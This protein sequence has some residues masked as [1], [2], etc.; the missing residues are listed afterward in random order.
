VAE[1]I[2]ISDT[3]TSQRLRR[4]M[5]NVLSDATDAHATGLR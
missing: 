5:Q 2:G 1:R 4:G 3:A